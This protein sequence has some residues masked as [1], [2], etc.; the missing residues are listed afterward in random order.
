[1]MMKMMIVMGDND[2]DDDDGNIDD[3]GHDDDNFHDLDIVREVA[4]ISL[5]KGL[6]WRAEG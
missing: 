6:T 4:F 1:M 2:N 5:D 3:H